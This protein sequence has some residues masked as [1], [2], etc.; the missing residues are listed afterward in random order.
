MVAALGLMLVAPQEIFGFE[1]FGVHLW[2]KKKN[3]IQ[4][5]ETIGEPKYYEV[6]IKV[7]AGRGEAGEKLV[8]TTSELV[9]DADKPASG[10]AGLLLKAR[11]DYRRILAAL[12]A[13]GHYG[14]SI[15]ITIN[16]QEAASLA[17]DSELP[18]HSAITITID[19]GE[20]YHFSHAAIHDL[21]PAPRK[22]KG[23]LADIQ[24]KGFA[25]GDV[26]RSKVI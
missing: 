8:E 5:E 7:V 9:R 3:D 21:P 20:V 23:N 14:G 22:N 12:Y 18:Q 24:E 11:D 16:G 19:E 4:V 1:L 17:S 6:T 15:S 13:Q 10:S 2:G 26:A 25:V